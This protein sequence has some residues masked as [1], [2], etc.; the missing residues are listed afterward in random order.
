MASGID[1]VLK[2]QRFWMK[3]RG[4]WT[5]RSER[6]RFKPKGRRGAPQPCRFRRNSA[7]GFQNSGEG[8]CESGG[9][10]GESV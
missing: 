6:E 5:R 8:F 2:A 4:H 1:K 10:S 9:V 7:A 3:T